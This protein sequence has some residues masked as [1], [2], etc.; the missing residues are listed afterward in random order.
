MPGYATDCDHV[1]GCYI[2]LDEESTALV[3]ELHPDVEELQQDVLG[4]LI[5]LDEAIRTK[6]HH[7]AYT[8]NQPVHLPW[9]SAGKLIVAAAL[10][11]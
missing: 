9:P 6:Q 10:D 1:S 11:F 2:H 3:I 7:V 8:A 4:R 5:A